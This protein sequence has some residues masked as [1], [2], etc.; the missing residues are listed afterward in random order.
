VREFVDRDHQ[1]RIVGVYL[2][3]D[4][5]EW[6]GRNISEKFVAELEQTE[7]IEV[8]GERDEYH[9]FAFGGPTFQTPLELRNRDQ[10]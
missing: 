9:S 6:T 8:C 4:R 7:N 10:S 5:R 3:C 1:A 2:T